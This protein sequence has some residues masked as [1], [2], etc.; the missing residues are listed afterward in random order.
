MNR[1]T[2]LLFFGLC[3]SGMTQ[4]AVNSPSGTIHFYGA[5]VESPCNINRGQNMVT[6]DCFRDGKNIIQTR[7]LTTSNLPNFTLP[8]ALGV[9][10]TQHI[11]NNPHLAI[12]TVVYN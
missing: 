12:M 3:T 8:K 11:N 9:V 4:A 2:M 1:L 7:A 6:T 5:I 10:T